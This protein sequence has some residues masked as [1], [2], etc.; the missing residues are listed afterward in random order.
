MIRME[1]LKRKIEEEGQSY[2]PRYVSEHV[3]NY[4]N[5]LG[6][7]YSEARINDAWKELKGKY[8]KISKEGTTVELYRNIQGKTRLK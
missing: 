2:I 6:A 1:N 8:R 5:D 4:I 7:S 3:E